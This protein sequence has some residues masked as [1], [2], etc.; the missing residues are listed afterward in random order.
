MTTR[1]SRT[2]LKTVEAWWP[3]V[4]RISSFLLGAGMIAWEVVPSEPADRFVM[5]FGV[6]LM[7]FLPLS[8]LAGGGRREGER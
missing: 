7:G 6:G 3:S 1:R 2:R 8:M 4:A 5:L